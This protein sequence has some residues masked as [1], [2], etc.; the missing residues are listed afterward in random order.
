[1]TGLTFETWALIVASFGMI[2]V[3][4]VG[5]YQA[6]FVMPEYFSSPPASLRRYQNDRSVWF[7]LPLHG[8]TLPF[9]ILSLVNNWSNDRMTLILISTICYTL[10]WIATFAFF[11]PGV[12]KFSKVDVDGP[13]SEELRVYGKKWL[14]RSSLR[15]VLMLA[16]AAALVIGL[17]VSPN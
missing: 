16:A 8:V 14:Q 12:I 10:A 17:G 2:A 6:T 1:V 7:W 15:L 3:A 9:L 13:P 5:C 4:A 11:I